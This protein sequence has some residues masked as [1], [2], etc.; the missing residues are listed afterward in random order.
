MPSAIPVAF[1]VYIHCTIVNV[2]E[3][4]DDLHN[5]KTKTTRIKLCNVVEQTYWFGDG[6]VG[7][8]KQCLT[9]ATVCN[10][11]LSSYKALIHKIHMKI[12][13]KDCGNNINT[14]I[15]VCDN[16][17]RST[18]TINQCIHIGGCG[19]LHIAASMRMT[20]E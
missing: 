15:T 11:F 10:V 1:P 4:L 3:R 14:A 12:I 19:F 7:G 17:Y 8:A 16:N 9:L 5:L 2:L 18:I 13:H 20:R 6:G